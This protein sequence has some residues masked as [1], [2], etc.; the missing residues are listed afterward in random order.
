MAL[1]L[2][3]SCPAIFTVISCT[4]DSIEYWVLSNRSDLIKGI[5]TIFLHYWYINSFGIWHYRI[6]TNKI[7]DL[8]L[9]STDTL[10]ESKFI[11]LIINLVL[12]WGVFYQDLLETIYSTWHSIIFE[13]QNCNFKPELISNSV[14]S[15][16]IYEV[17]PDLA[18]HS[19]GYG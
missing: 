11:F 14:R 3:Y 1:V 9:I 4:Q 5:K 2:L 6:H 18:S 10:L 12:K 8:T 7:I 17:L 13:A 16:F 19:I 15:N